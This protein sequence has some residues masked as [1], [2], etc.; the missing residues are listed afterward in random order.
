MISL[1]W[2]GATSQ[3]ACWSWNMLK[4]L[5]PSLSL[6]AL[7]QILCML[8]LK[9][10][11]GTKFL[12]IVLFWWDLLVVATEINFDWSKAEI[13]FIVRMLGSLH[14]HQKGWQSDSQTMQAGT[15]LQI[16]SKTWW[17]LHG[18]W[19]QAQ[20]VVACATS[21]LVGGTGDHHDPHSHPFPWKFSPTALPLPPKWV[22]LGLH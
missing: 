4:I 2:N 10:K 13:V 3:V 16:R 14:N 5:P 15:T 7:P 1:S 9:K 8:S 20:D 19:L 18:Q 21:L 6:F 11:K 17:G 22:F 12:C